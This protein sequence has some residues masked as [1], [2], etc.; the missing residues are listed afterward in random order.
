MVIKAYLL[1]SRL[2]TSSA[3]EMD[4]F[5]LVSLPEATQSLE[6]QQLLLMTTT[7]PR[8]NNNSLLLT[9]VSLL[10]TAESRPAHPAAQADSTLQHF[11]FEGSAE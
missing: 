10:L 9:D 11:Y 6:L 5:V 3:Q 8:A 2:V 4:E 7:T 1:E